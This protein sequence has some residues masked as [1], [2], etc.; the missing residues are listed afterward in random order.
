APLAVRFPRGGVGMVIAFSLVIF[1]IYWSGLT[2]GEQL[3]DKGIIPP[4]FGMWAANII[5]LALG[6][7]SLLKFGR[8][9]S[10]LRGNTLDELASY[11][12]RL[13]GRRALAGGLHGA[14]ERVRVSQP[15]G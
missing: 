7:L 4:F 10:S 3:G 9:T 5:F 14:T 8:E 2:G 13:R 6:I 1:A 11:L 12:R 15:G